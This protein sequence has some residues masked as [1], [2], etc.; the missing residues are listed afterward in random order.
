MT[1]LSQP[2]QAQR[3]SD[4][5]PW[6]HHKFVWLLIATPLI[7]VIVA[8]LSTVYIA[9]DG[10]DPVISGPS[11]KAS[12]GLTEVPAGQARNHAATGVPPEDK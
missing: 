11:L 5:G 8:G 7:A 3:A 2:R 10:A 12:Q 4:T 9:V 6:W 1:T